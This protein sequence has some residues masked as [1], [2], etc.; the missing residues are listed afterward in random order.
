LGGARRGAIVFADPPPT[1]IRAMI[2]RCGDATGDMTLR[3][4]VIPIR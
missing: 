3:E 4:V 2:E 1:R